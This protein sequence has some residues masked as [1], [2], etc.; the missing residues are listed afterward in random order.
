MSSCCLLAALAASAGDLT[1]SVSN[2][3]ATGTVYALVF[4]STDTFVDLRDPLRVGILPSGSTGSVHVAGLPAGDYAVV[5]YEDQNG[6]RQLDKNF[7]GIPREPLGFSN[8]HW[9]QGPPSFTRASFRLEDDES[10]AVDVDLRSILGRRGRIGAGVGVIAQSSPYRDSDGAVFQPIPAITYIGDRL[11]VLG[12]R[13]QVGVIRQGDSALAVT[14]SYRVGAY[15][16][17]DSPYLEGLGDRDGTMMGGLSVRT[18]VPYG[19]RV[20]AGYEHDLLDRSGGGTGRLGVERSF[21]RGILTVS[22]QLAVNWM[23]ADLADYEFGVPADRART[24]RPVYRVGDAFIPEAGVGLF[25]ELKGAWRL[26]LNGSGKLLPAEI[27]DSPIVEQDYVVGGFAA[28]TR[29]F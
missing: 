1:I 15:E 27:A 17:D 23:S 12:P 5:V 26:L 29:L 11:Q 24:D 9:P 18:R 4:N 19:F 13:L 14:A 25:V 22:P 21:Q 8:R 6:N 7:I 16:E 2:P 20:G 3:P 28:V 10:R